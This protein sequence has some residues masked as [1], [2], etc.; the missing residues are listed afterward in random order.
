[1]LQLGKVSFPSAHTSSNFNEQSAPGSDGFSQ[2]EKKKGLEYSKSNLIG[3]SKIR[4]A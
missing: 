3:Y 1:M 4:T 2:L